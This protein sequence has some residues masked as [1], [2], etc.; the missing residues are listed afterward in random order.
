MKKLVSLILVLC[1]ACMLIP[2]MAESAAV[3]GEWYVKTIKMG[4]QEMD[5][6]SLGMSITMT[7]NEDGTAIMVTS[8]Q[9]PATANWTLDGDQLTIA[10][11]DQVTNMTGT[12]AEDTITLE[13][14]GQFMV[15]TRE[16]PAAIEVAPVKAAA[17]ADEF[18]GN[19][20]L[21]LM[22]MEGS[23]IDLRAMGVT[24]GI[25]IS[26]GNLEIVPSSEEDVYSLVIAMLGLT[27][28]GFEDGALKLT[29]ATNPDEVTATAELL[30]DG[31]I[32]IA[33]MNTS[34]AE[35][36]VI[37]LA[38]SAAAEEPAA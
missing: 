34:T 18:Y 7:L 37:Y 24:T 9:E 13:Q 21:A 3:T 35:A 4:E 31:M 32:R 10:S 1:L 20:V 33:T 25:N 11:E 19:Y 6:A 14:N 36:L 30:E 28:A 2:A 8:G 29:S 15:L 38:P 26:E 22:E 12:V 23:I 17:S 5:V 16:A 27:P